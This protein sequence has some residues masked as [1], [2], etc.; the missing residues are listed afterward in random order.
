LLDEQSH[1]VL[2]DCAVGILIEVLEE[3]VEFFVWQ[4]AIFAQLDEEVL[5]KGS[6]LRLAEGATAVL[7]KVTPYLI[8]KFFDREFCRG[9][10]FLWC[11]YWS[12]L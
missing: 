10:T 8:N 6:G 1:L 7:V 2:R 9:R 5:H 3:G 11:F 4:L 12:F